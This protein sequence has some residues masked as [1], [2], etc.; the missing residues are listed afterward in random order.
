MA[1]TLV[2]IGRPTIEGKTERGASSPAKP[3]L[4]MPLPLSITSATPSCPPASSPAGGFIDAG[5]GAPPP[6][7]ISAMPSSGVVGSP[8][9]TEADGLLCP[10]ELCS[11]VPRLSSSMA[12]ACVAHACVSQWLPMAGLLAR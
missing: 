4:H 7:V 3:A 8:F 1:R 5:A 12:R 6:D 10:G 9:S 11:G 2:I